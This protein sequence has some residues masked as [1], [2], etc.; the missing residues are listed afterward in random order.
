MPRSYSIS[1]DDFPSTL[2][3]PSICSRIT[4][5]GFQSWLLS[6]VLQSTRNT[7]T[8]VRHL[9]GQHE[10][11]EQV[12]PTS[13]Q[14]NLP[15]C[16]KRPRVNDWAVQEDLNDLEEEQPPVKP[17]KKMANKQA[18]LDGFLT[19]KYNARNDAL[20]LVCQSN[21]SLHEVVSSDVVRRLLTRSYPGDPPPPKSASTLSK[22]LNDDACKI[23]DMLRLKFTEIRAQGKSVHYL[24]SYGYIA[25]CVLF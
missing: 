2:M 15:L 12:S 25:F 11:F 21:M 7:S 17:L 4:P 5:V 24:I 9:E 1:F 3:L 16:F 14:G 6:Q 20:R 23:R 10:V 18:Q 22:Y 8:L 19:T 13:S